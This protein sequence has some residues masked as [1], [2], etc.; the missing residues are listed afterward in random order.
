VF[1]KGNPLLTEISFGFTKEGYDN[2]PGYWDR[3]IQWHEGK[4]N[5]YGWMVENL[6]ENL[7]TGKGQQ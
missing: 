6:I 1:F 5:P 7:E 4:F 2:C 3:K